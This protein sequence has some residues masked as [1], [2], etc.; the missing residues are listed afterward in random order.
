MSPITHSVEVSKIEAV[1][2][3]EVDLGH[4]PRNLARHECP[5]TALLSTRTKGHS[6]HSASLGNGHKKTDR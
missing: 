2:L 5:A 6:L 1:L 3:T 4:R